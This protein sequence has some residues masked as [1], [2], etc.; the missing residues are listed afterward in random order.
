VE[1]GLEVEVLVMAAG[2]PVPMSLVES[3]RTARETDNRKARPTSTGETRRRRNPKREASGSRPKQPALETHRA[4]MKD[5][6]AEED[7]VAAGGSNVDGE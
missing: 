2:S 1:Q 6:E 3:R 7:L 5:L 4:V